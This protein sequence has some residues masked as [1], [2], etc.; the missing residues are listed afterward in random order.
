ML[1]AVA[2]QTG[3]VN[4]WSPTGASTSG[5]SWSPTPPRCPSSEWAVSVVARTPSC[6]AR[7]SQCG[8]D[9]PWFSVMV[10][11]RGNAEGYSGV[12]QALF[13]SFFLQLQLP[14]CQVEIPLLLIDMSPF[15]S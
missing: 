14:F 2:I 10:K 1:V 5:T 9:L 12:S 13:D 15:S 6:Y 7:I 4:V 8:G 11:V 3:V